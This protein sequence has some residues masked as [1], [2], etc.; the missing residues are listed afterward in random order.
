MM[1]RLSKSDIRKKSSIL[2]HP[3]FTLFVWCQNTLSC[4][5]GAQ[6]SSLVV[7]SP[8]LSGAKTLYHVPMAIRCSVYLLLHP[9]CPVPIHSIMSHWGPV[10]QFT[11]YFTLFVRCQ[12]TLSCPT[13]DQMSSLPVTSPSLSGANTLCHVLLAIRCPVYLLLYPLCPVPIHSIMS[14][15]GSDVQFTCYFTLFCQY[16]LSCPTGDQMSS[17]PVTSPSLSGANKPYHV[18]LGPRCPV[19]QLPQH[20]KKLFI[21]KEHERIL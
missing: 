5:T 17:L 9:L 4:P 21:E 18:L 3:I 14:H 13:G 7:T 2:L 19:Q 16:T 15:W 8:S 12:Y 20:L 11:C 10:V 1:E 6:M